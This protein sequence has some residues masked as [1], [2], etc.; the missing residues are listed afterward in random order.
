MRQQ[1]R[2]AGL[3]SLALMM[4]VIAACGR[5]AADT[6]TTVVARLGERPLYLAELTSYL[7]D[8]MPE[9]S[10]GEEPA[11]EALERVKSRLL[12]ALVEERLLLVEAERRGLVVEDWEVAAYIGMD[13]EEESGADAEVLARRRLM[14]QK[15]REGTI[16]SLPP[17]TDG[18][19]ARYAEQHG[20]RLMSE[21]RL[22]LRALMLESEEKAKKVYRDIR[23]RRI[24]FTEAVVA[25]EKYPGQG[26]PIPVAWSGLSEEVRAALEK[27]KVGQVSQPVEMQGDF[28]LF[29]IES[30]INDPERLAAER[31][32]R[33]RR[34]LEDLRRQQALEELLAELRERNEVRL[35]LRRL[36]FRY[37]P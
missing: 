17:L 14:V 2:A 6:E 31:V 32:H 21:R 9:L 13:E 12:D 8:N 22:E 34:E 7:R 16:L 33:A 19:I 25:Y 27:L 28:Y 3:V 36:P 23:R 30:W 4:G 18:E 24:T 11:E 26:R 1:I 29:K 5:Q 37:R 20:E 35:E 15:L 10:G